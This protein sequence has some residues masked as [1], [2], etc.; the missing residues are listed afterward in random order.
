MSVR[1]G[2]NTRDTLELGECAAIEALGPPAG[3]VEKE[4]PGMEKRQNFPWGR[5]NQE[6]AITEARE[7]CFKKSMI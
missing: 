3:L 7:E 4:P 5:E 2:I 6:N 1:G